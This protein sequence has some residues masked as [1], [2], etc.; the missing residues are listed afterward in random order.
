M[1]KIREYLEGTKIPPM[2]VLDMTNACNLRCIHCPLTEMIEKPGYQAAHLSWEYFSKIVDELTEIGEPVLLRMVGNGEPMIHPE[3]MKMAEYACQSENIT[4]NLTTNGLMMTDKKIK[5]ILEMGMDLIDVSIDAMTKPVYEEVRSGGKYETF[6]AKMFNLLDQRSKKK[7]KTRLMVSFISQKENRH[8]ADAFRTFWEPLVDYVMIRN[9]HSALGQVKTEESA[10]YNKAK[11]IERY[12]CPHLWKRLTVDFHGNIKF[13]AHDW[14]DEADLILGNIGDVSLAEV[15]TGSHLGGLREKH[16]C[17]T[18]DVG[19]V[20]GPCTDWA[21][22]PWEYG[23]ERL[24]D[25]VVHEESKLLPVL[26][27]LGSS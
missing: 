24:V 10:T 1:K 19:H 21:S 3:F 5:A 4:V 6:C 26:P 12:P 7:A 8:E 18:I 20:C 2:V 22:S 16:A 23:Y 11:S 14:T 15:W 13:C 27:L 9:L 17:N 25:R